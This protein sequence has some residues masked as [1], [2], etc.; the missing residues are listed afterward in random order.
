MASGEDRFQLRSQLCYLVATRCG[1]PSDSASKVSAC[2]AGRCRFDSWVRKSSWRRKWQSTPVFLP[3]K[4]HGQ[5]I[6]AGYSLNSRKESDTTENTHTH[7]HTHTHTH[8]HTRCD[9]DPA[10]PPNMLALIR[11]GKGCYLHFHGRLDAAL[12][13]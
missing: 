2:N 6:L 1:L 7:S 3:E 12:I 5:R 8:T 4:S 13:P 11:M 10:Q 9:K